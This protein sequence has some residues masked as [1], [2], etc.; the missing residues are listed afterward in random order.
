MTDRLGNTTYFPFNDYGQ[1]TSQTDALGVTT[2]YLYD[3]S[4]HQLQQVTRDGK[5][6]ESFTYDSIGRARTHTDTTG[7]TL[8]YDYDNLNNVKKVTYPDG[9]FVS[10][11]Y[12]S[13]CPYLLDNMT[14]RSGRT[15]YYSYDALRRLTETINPEGGITKNFYDA[16][17]NMVRLI[18]PNNNL[19]NF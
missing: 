1:I 9:K 18:D 14:D 3:F 12:S 8:T 11:S 4:N 16:N 7:L 5:T 15:T 17:S 10:Y 19:T 6:L 13:C 2:N